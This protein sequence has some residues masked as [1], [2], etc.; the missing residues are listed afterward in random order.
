MSERGLDQ[1]VAVITGAAGGI[2]RAVATAFA[3]EGSRLVL[4]DIDGTGLRAITDQLVSAGTEVE[5]VLA[6][7]TTEQGAASVVQGGDRA[8]RNG[9]HPCQRGRRE[10]ARADGGRRQPRRLGLGA[11][12][13]SDLDVPHVPLRHS[14]HGTTGSG[15]HRERLV[16][17]WSS[18]HEGQPGI[19]P[20][21]RPVLSASPAP[22]P[23]I[24]CPK[25]CGST[26]SLPARC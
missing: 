24:T 12:P 19:L 3:Q 14:T 15:G 5:A 7:V 22:S 17:S 23:S 16:G 13:Q 21:R 26:P 4:G 25:A 9:R 18:G 2:A 20:R 8:L 6:D 10:P 1:K 11:A